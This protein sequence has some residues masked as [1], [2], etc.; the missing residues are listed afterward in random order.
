[1]LL[2]WFPSKYSMPL[3]GLSVPSDLKKSQALAA[4]LF[5]TNRLLREGPSYSCKTLGIN[6]KRY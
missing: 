1:M 4:S 3:A 2:C 6:R 5:A